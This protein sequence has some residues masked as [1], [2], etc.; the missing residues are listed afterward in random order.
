[1]DDSER[2]LLFGMDNP[3]G[4]GRQWITP[5]GRLEPGEAPRDAAVRELAEETGLV[6]TADELGSPVAY[7]ETSWDAPD[8]VLYDVRDEFW[9]LRTTS[10]TPN[11]S[12]MVAGE[13]DVLTTHR[14]W[15]VAELSPTPED[16][17]LP[18]GLGELTAGLLGNGPPDEPWRLP[19]A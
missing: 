4:P 16:V 19:G 11:T 2:V 3:E 9:L 13:E 18:V 10:F 17:I 14:W 8:G 1:M 12:G 15:P 6:V 7:F 5:G